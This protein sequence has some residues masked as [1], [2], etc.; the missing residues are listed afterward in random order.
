VASLSK[1]LVLFNMGELCIG[2]QNCYENLMDMIEKN[3]GAIWNYDLNNSDESNLS[4]SF[5]AS[6][7]QVPTEFAKLD[8]KF[9]FPPPSIS[10]RQ[11]KLHFYD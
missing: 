9:R 5:N 6:P 11:W 10:K 3:I 1:T 4:F 7:K 8:V 2:L